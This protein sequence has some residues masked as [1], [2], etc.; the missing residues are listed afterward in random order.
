MK[1]LLHLSARL[2][3]VALACC[4]SLSAYAQKLS[5]KGTVVDET[6]APLIGASVVVMSGE[7]IIGGGTTTDIS[8]SYAVSVEPGQT[9]DISF[10]GY[11]NELVTITAQKTVYNVQL[12]VDSQAVE[13]VVV[14]GYGTE[15][16]V[17]LT[18]SVS[19]VSTEEFNSRP[20]TQLSTALQGIAPGVTVTTAGGAP[21][22]DT[23]NTSRLY[24]AST[25]SGIETGMGISSYSGRSLPISV[26]RRNAACSN[27]KRE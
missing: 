25:S 1:K 19:S 24:S 4:F 5:V 22:A 2:L 17:N 9:L 11:K 10:M 16:K 6:G 20:I 3:L 27:R 18:G 15:K 13:E 14:V 8:G 26:S 7:K 23:G 21:G 12:K